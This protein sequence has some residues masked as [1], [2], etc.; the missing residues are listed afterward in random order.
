MDVQK[1]LETISEVEAWTSRKE[2]LEARLKAL[3]RSERS[4]M[5]AELEIVRQQLFHYQALLEDMKRSV[6]QP[7]MTAFFERV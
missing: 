3:P 4:T 1:I 7:A 6:T 5:R 2:A